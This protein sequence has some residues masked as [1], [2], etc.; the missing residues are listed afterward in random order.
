MNL[1]N[2]LINFNNI[3]KII[4]TLKQKNIKLNIA[5]CCWF[6]YSYQVASYI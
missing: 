2:K 3:F 1:F 5:I 4:N 6:K